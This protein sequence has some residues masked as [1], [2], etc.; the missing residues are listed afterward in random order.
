M[1]E[2]TKW[3]STSQ[4]FDDVADGLYQE[5]VRNKKD[6]VRRMLMKER[7]LIEDKTKAEKEL[8]KIDKSLTETQEKITKFKAWDWSVLAQF[9]SKPQAPTEPTPNN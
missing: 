7:Q 2:I 8:A 5:D 6:N 4:L 1:T 3:P 9:S